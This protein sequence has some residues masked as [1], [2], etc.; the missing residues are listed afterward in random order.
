M[1]LH[2]LACKYGGIGLTSKSYCLLGLIATEPVP[3]TQ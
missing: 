3:E 2:L 1:M